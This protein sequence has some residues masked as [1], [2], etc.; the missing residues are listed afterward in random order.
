M[1]IEAAYLHSYTANMQLKNW[2]DLRYLLAVKRGHT[3]TAAARLMGVDDTTVSR[4]LSVL[5]STTGVQLCSRLPGGSIQL[6][7]HGELIAHR[8]ENMEHEIELIGEVLNPDRQE[9]VGLVRLTSVPILVNR[10]L[11]PH[12]DMLLTAH[13]RLDIELVPESRDL[14]LTHREADIAVRLARPT[15]GGTNVKA[16]RIGY[17]DY[18]V[19]ASC[20][21]S[22]EEALRLPWITYEEAMAHIPQAQ[23]IARTMNGRTDKL[24]GLRV[25]DTETA[26]EAVLAGLGRTLLPNV[27][28]GPENRLVRLSMEDK[29]EPPARELWLLAHANQFELRRIRAVIEWIENLVDLTVKK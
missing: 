6:T 3:L 29:A 8:V 4:R 12:I 16:R 13:P 15:T 23:W 18:S 20:E 27:I 17:L 7:A 5:Q 25:H 21:Y 19:Y 1:Q 11:T 26:L 24:S 22:I 10:L 9:C 14:S 28:A 2:N